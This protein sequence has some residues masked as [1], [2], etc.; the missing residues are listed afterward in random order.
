M[1]MTNVLKMFLV[2]IFIFFYDFF[3]FEQSELISIME[4][5]V[6]SGII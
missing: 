1:L 4:A 6:K 5:R 3:L 2:F